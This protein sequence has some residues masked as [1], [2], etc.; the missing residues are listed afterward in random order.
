MSDYENDAR[1]EKWL[2]E[3]QLYMN[4]V[5][6]IV[7]K[8]ANVTI[9]SALI[10]SWKTKRKTKATGNLRNASEIVEGFK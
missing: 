3:K 2:E 10:L 9:P 4:G 8:I 7:I 5:V 6:I 1:R